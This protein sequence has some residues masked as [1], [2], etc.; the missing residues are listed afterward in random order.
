MLSSHQKVIVRHLERNLK[1]E[2]ARSIPETHH[3]PK[4][5]WAWLPVLFIVVSAR[6]IH[7]ESLG[8]SELKRK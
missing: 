8:A 7:Y 6:V 5:L 4:H 1:H 3:V 2:Y